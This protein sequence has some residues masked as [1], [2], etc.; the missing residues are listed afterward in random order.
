MCNS[1]NI[2][3]ALCAHTV[4]TSNQD[5]QYWELC[6]NAVANGNKCTFAV[7][8]DELEEMEGRCPDCVAEWEEKRKKWKGRLRVKRNLLDGEAKIEKLR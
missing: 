4:I 5:E 6:L 8:G 3:Y 1:Y 2:R 7:L